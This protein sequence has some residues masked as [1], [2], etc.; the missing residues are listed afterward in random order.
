M[1]I[2]LFSTSFS[3]DWSQTFGTWLSELFNTDSSYGLGWR[4]K[5][6][7]LEPVW[8]V[9][10]SIELNAE[11]AH[12]HLYTSAD[13]I[14]QTTAAVRFQGNLNKLYAVERPR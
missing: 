6:L 2:S 1:A 13:E 7:G 4:R 3:Q 11:I 9:D 14:A 12:R 8:N 10:P 5:G